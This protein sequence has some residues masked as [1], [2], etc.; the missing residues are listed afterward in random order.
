MEIGAATVRALRDSPWRVAL[1]ASSSW[2]H[3]FLCEGNNRLWPDGESDNRLY[4]ALQQGDYDTWQ[5]TTLQQF[6]DAGQ[7]EVLNWCALLGAMRELGAE[8]VWS[9]LVETDAFNSNKAFAVYR[10]A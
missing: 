9:E 6:E 2:S 8:L 4:R 5:A 1:V 10:P 7:Q 3:A